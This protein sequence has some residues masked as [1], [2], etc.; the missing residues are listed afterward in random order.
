MSF[1]DTKEL[2]ETMI[3]DARRLYFR[4]PVLC[5]MSTRSKIMSS[6]DTR[7]GIDHCLMFRTIITSKGI[8]EIISL[9]ASYYE[10]LDPA[11]SD[12]ATQ[13]SIRPRILQMTVLLLSLLNDNDLLE[14]QDFL[15]HTYKFKAGRR[16]LELA[17]LKVIPLMSISP[18]VFL[19]SLVP[20]I[21]G[22]PLSSDQY[23]DHSHIW[24][25]FVRRILLDGYLLPG[26]VMGL[27]RE[28]LSW[29]SKW[30]EGGL[31]FT[32]VFNS[33]QY[34]GRLRTVNEIPPMDL[35]PEAQ[36]EEVIVI[37]TDGSRWLVSSM[38]IESITCLSPGIYAVRET[39]QSN[40]TFD[41]T[42][43]ETLINDD[44]YDAIRTTNAII[45]EANARLTQPRRTDTVAGRFSSV[46]AGRVQRL[47]SNYP[48]CGQIEFKRVVNSIQG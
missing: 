26:T 37:M 33:L 7:Y 2:L 20:A 8:R 24:D 10:S 11:G 48:Q 15:E 47:R 36:L 21:E 38:D 40:G 6:E 9:S 27:G 41:F 23:E 22:F 25:T 39:G 44:L 34:G 19:E 18:R 4:S 17:I 32:D 42:V 43:Q 45:R 31:R 14:I 3:E 29:I 28:D 12:D 16:N 5:R 30:P 13:R 35:R 46:I 1:E